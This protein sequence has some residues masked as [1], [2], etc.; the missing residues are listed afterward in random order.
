MNLPNCT[1]LGNRGVKYSYCLKR[2]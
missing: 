1:V 2:F